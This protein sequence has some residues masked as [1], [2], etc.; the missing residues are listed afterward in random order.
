MMSAIKNF[1]LRAVLGVSALLSVGSAANA[2]YF[3]A[4]SNEGSGN[5]TIQKYDINGVSLGT[6][7]TDAALTNPQSLVAGTNGDLYVNNQDK[8]LR[9]DGQT[10]AYMGAVVTGLT[11]S[12]SFVFGP[13]GNFYVANGDASNGSTP[14]ILKFDGATGASLGV[15]A[16]GGG[17][18]EPMSLAFAPD[19]N[20]Y[21]GDGTDT[22]NALQDTIK[23]YDGATGAFVDTFASGDGNLTDPNG[24]VI[25]PDGKLYVAI[26][27]PNYGN[28]SFGLVHRYDLATGAKDV[29][30]TDGLG[31]IQEPFGLT[32]GPNG[33]L[34][35][36]SGDTG[37]V[38]RYDGAT[39][40]VVG[41]GAFLSGLSDPKGLIYVPA[42]TPE[43]GSVALL[44]GMATVG[45]GVLRR[46]RK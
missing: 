5:A 3:Y 15:F 30:V 16:T 8:I 22:A 25:G 31:G 4:T 12:K 17:M 34:F 44:L 28:A 7:A 21:V 43:P 36:S 2:Q 1:S 46:R 35:V 42:A 13:D 9:F 41:S 33:D 40:G 23:R 18:Q 39:G 45:A 37:E 27:G 11:D 38:Y 20:L 14:Q 19:G 6:F 32:F 29:F 10:G 26:E 24:M